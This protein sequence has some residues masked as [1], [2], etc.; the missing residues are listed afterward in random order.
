MTLFIICF[1]WFII[2]TEFVKAIIRRMEMLFEEG[3]GKLG[4]A[5]SF[6]VSLALVVSG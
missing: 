2:G 1:V 5:G 4:G 6:P 3:R